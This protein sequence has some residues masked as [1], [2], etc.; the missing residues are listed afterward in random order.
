VEGGTRRRLV[1]IGEKMWNKRGRSLQRGCK[2]NGMTL[3]KRDMDPHRVAA[4]E[5][6][7][8]VGALDRQGRAGTVGPPKSRGRLTTARKSRKKKLLAAGDNMS[9]RKRAGG[10]EEQGRSDAMLRKRRTP[11]RHEDVST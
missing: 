5:S 8:G 9:Y 10:A 11:E 3:V 4:K 6:T 2:E 7:P 1:A